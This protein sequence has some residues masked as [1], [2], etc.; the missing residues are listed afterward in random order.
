MNIQTEAKEKAFQ[1]KDEF[2]RTKFQSHG[3]RSHTG[4]QGFRILTGNGKSILER[5]FVERRM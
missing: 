2:G 1:D 3:L 4:N 5:D